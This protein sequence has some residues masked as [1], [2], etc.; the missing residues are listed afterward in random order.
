MKCH[1][2][3]YGGR[4]EPMSQPHGYVVYE[5]PSRINRMPIVAILTTHSGNRKTGDVPQLWIL[6]RDEKPAQAAAYG[7]DAA[8]CG[9]CPHRGIA[10]D[11]KI[12]GRTCYVTLIHGPRSVWEAYQAGKYDKVRPDVAGRAVAG[13]T[14]RLGAYGDPGALP[15]S[16]IDA[17]TRYAPKHTG[18]THQWRKRADLSVLTMASVDTPAEAAEAVN[19]GW[20]YFRVAADNQPLSGEVLCP[21]SVEAGKRTDCA[22]CGLCSGNRTNAKNIYI[23]AHGSGANIIRNK[24]MVTV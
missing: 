23:P 16:V 13:R 6:C 8:V 21:A 20:R 3:W 18:Y 14:V 2:P 11:G 15:V 12:I 9:R 1:G 17:L 5:G 24:A 7:N 22:R 10:R 4:N 19:A